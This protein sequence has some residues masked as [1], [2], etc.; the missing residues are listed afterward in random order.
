MVTV[1]FIVNCKGEPGCFHIYE[2]DERYK[3][4]AYPKELTEG[5]LQFVKNLGNW[6]IGKYS[7]TREE[8]DY[9]AYLSFRIKNG[10]ITHVI[11]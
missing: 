10:K 1:R 2:V 6:P 7:N 8:T 11:P 5:L 9:Y 4:M 3:I